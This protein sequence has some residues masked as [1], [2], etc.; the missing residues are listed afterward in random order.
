MSILF[1]ILSTLVFV[2]ES[3]PESAQMFEIKGISIL[4]QFER[5]CI[6]W[7]T[8]E[9]LI[10]AVTSPDKVEFAKSPLTVIDVVS[11]FPF[12]IL[13]FFEYASSD[14]YERIA[15]LGSLFIIIRVLRIFKLMRHSDG[16]KVFVIAIRNSVK[17]LGV[18]G[19][20]VTMSVILFSSLIYFAEYEEPGT[21]FTSIPS[22][23]W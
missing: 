3:L 23:F 4:R 19:L 17:E 1:I 13:L 8:I 10:R 5:A 2:L 21:L 12:Y 20:L 7:F 6:C 16:L 15:S 22:S 9:F 18:L 14:I 11:V